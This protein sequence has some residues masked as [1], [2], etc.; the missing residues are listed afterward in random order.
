[1]I[2]FNKEYWK[3]T[4]RGMLGVF[5]VVPT[6]GVLCYLTICEGEGWAAYTLVGM[7]LA[8]LTFYGFQIKKGGK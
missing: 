4:V 3:A 5:V 6:V 7:A 1:M 2:K 8:V